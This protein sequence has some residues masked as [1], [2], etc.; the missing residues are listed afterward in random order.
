MRYPLDGDLSTGYDYPSF[1]QLG[2]GR[3]DAQSHKMC[4]S[5]IFFCPISVTISLYRL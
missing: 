3:Q 4:V 5:A 2:P 1:E